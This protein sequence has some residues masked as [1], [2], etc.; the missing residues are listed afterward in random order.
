MATKNMTKKRLMRDIDTAVV[1]LGEAR[2]ALVLA[3]RR[4]VNDGDL[5]DSEPENDTEVEEAAA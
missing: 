2:D 4:L 5:L 1:R 3:R